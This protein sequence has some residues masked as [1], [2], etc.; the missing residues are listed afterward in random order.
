MENKNQCPKGL[1]YNGFTLVFIQSF[2]LTN[3]NKLDKL[4]NYV[5]AIENSIDN[6]IFNLRGF[7]N[8]SLIRRY[9]L[10]GFNIYIKLDEEDGPAVEGFVHV[11]A[12]LFFDNT[13]TIS[14]R[15]V[16]DTEKQLDWSEEGFCVSDQAF[17][18]DSLIALAGIPLGTEHWDLEAGAGQ[19]EIDTEV[20]QIK[21]SEIYVGESG[22]W[23]SSPESFEGQKQ[24]FIEIQNRYKRLFTKK[25]SETC[26]NDYMF[27]YID[28]WEDVGHQEGV[29]FKKMREGEIIE[30]IEKHHQSEMIGLLT[31]YP[32]EW[33]Y[34]MNADF[35]YICG[36]NIAIDTDDL[37]LVNQNLCIVFGTYGLRGKDSPTDWSTHLEERAF[38]HV[39]WPEYLLIVE[40][41]IAKKQAINSALTHFI[42]NTI[43]VSNQKNTRKLIEQNALLTLG[44][45]N[46][47]LK[48]DAVRFSRYISHK[49]MY[50]RT[51]ERFGLEKDYNQL[52]NAVGQIDQSLNNVTNIR[53]IRQANLLNVILGIISVASL[54]SILLTPAE[55]PFLKNVAHDGELAF[56]GGATIIVFT[57]L[58]ILI[59]FIVGVILVIRNI[60]YKNR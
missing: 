1:I 46:I 41:I 43:K 23:L 37:I 17:T 2:S 18:T 10:K 13:V 48:L 45:S 33:P 47:L 21:I 32:F 38:Y 22:D 29:N 3:G 30:H 40:M 60:K 31:L 9:R 15:L 49:I 24:A 36:S 56:T 5:H 11:E 35:E 58:L 54:F 4:N 50:E 14:Y 53:E 59:S 16:I 28:V 39:S 34:R 20:A 19:T 57:F 7:A 51:E 44:I 8:K 42:Q 26:Y 12:S 55:I 25:I 6:Q 52:Q 27:V